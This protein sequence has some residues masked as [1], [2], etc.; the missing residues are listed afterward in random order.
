MKNLMR[1]RYPGVQPVLACLPQSLHIFVSGNASLRTPRPNDSLARP[2]GRT[3]CSHRQRVRTETE[4]ARE[5]P[6]QQTAAPATPGVAAASPS[7]LWQEVATTRNVQRGL[8]YGDPESGTTVALNRLHMGNLMRFQGPRSPAPDGTVAA[9]MTG[10]VVWS[11]WT[12]VRRG[13][14]LRFGF[15][16]WCPSSY[17]M[18]GVKDA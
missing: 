8:G 7:A 1:F 9:T 11:E 3:T 13:H 16:G 10:T 4:P 18:Q 15:G 2:G 5:P 14:G 17:A 12:G 6:V